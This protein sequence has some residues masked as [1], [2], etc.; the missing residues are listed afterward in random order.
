M[1]NKKLK[2]YTGN[3]NQYVQTR[4]ELKENQMKQYKWEQDQIAAMKEYIARFRHGSAKLARQA[5]IKEKT[6][7]KM[8]RCGITENV[9][10]DSILVFRFTDVGKLP[11][12]VLQFLEVSFGYTPDN[13]IYKNLDF[14]VDL[15][16]RIVLV[17][18]NRFGKSTL[19]KL[20][21]GDLFPTE[22][23]VNVI[24]T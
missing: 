6:L 14:G 8:E 22:R 23:M 3:Y 5:Q 15:D 19:L 2:L 17:G 9:G 10:R 13:L 18:P 7:A 11:P 4:S 21:I 20:M 1:Q 24:I 12:Q 16:S